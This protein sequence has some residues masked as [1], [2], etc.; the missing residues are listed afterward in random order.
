[1]GPDGT[2][3]GYYYPDYAPAGVPHTTEPE[4]GY[5][6]DR[7]AWGHGYAREAVRGMWNYLS[8]RRPDLR[9]ISLIHP[10]NARSLRLATSFGVTLV[11]RIMTWGRPFDR[12]AW[13]AG[14]SP[15]ID[16]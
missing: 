15:S 5:T 16:R 14:N 3:L 12:Y 6:L 1:M 13:P 2:H 9:V 10:D 4:L 8:T 7:A 11:D